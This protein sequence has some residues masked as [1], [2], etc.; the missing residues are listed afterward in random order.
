[1]LDIPKRISL[2]TQAAAT[3]RKGIEEGSWKGS[4]PSE[5]R[6][7]ELLKVSRPTVRT[8][9]HLLSKEGLIETKQGQRSHIVTRVRRAPKA[10]NRLIA[11]ITNEPISHM[12]IVAHHGI[13]ELRAH[14]AEQGFATMIFICQ[15]RSESVR[16]RKLETFLLQTRVVCCLLHSGSRE[17]Q[18]WFAAHSIPALL[19]GSCYASVRLPS[20]DVDYRSVCRHAAGVFLAKGHKRLALIV[21]DSEL[22]GDLDSEAGFLEAVAQSSQ[23]DELHTVVVRHN[24]TAKNIGAKLDTLFGSSRAPTAL[25]VAKPQDVFIV[26]IYLLKR[27]LTVPNKISLIARDPDSLFG[28]VDPPVSHYR[29]DLDGYNH[30]L[31]RLMVQMVNQ[32]YLPPESN[33]VFPRFFAGGTVKNIA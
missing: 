9:L 4:L 29:F 15:G 26:I 23:S 8:A 33:M 20:L 16:R 30:R 22:A 31:T 19:L 7:C 12:S 32:G 1:M 18:Q 17:L 28:K 27:G 25:L 13:S 2:S 3:I 5:R 10:V 14:L 24:G 21:P 11:I 6:L